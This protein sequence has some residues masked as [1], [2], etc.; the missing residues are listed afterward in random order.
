MYADDVIDLAAGRGIA[1]TPASRAVARQLAVSEGPI[2]W[3]SISSIFNPPRVRTQRE[4]LRQ[5]LE[6]EKQE[7]EVALQEIASRLARHTSHLRELDKYPD[8]DPFENGAILRFEKRFPRS[9]QTYTYVALKKDDAWWVTGSRAPQGITWDEFVDFMGIGV[10]EVY[11]VNAT[12][13]VRGAS[14]QVEC[15][16]IG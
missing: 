16:V 10:K 11:H 7:L 5:R 9:E 4:N 14:Q 12:K 8:A 15:K 3:R 6:R 13:R 1:V 2:D